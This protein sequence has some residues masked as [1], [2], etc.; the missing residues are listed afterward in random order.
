V[1][2]PKLG[3]E[4]DMKVKSY[5]VILLLNY[6]GNIVE[7]VVLTMLQDYSERKGI[8]HLGQSRWSKNWLAV[9]VVGDLI[10]KT[11]EV[12]SRKIILSTLC[13][14]LEV[15]FQS[16]AKKYLVSKIRAIKINECLL[17]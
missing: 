16:M 8:C 5:R 2:I 14:D 12:W 10:V 13:M 7:K 9:D 3:K 15:A 17:R 11:Q 4:D 6:E 1:T